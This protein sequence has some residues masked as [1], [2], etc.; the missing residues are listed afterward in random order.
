MGS[1]GALSVIPEEAMLKIIADNIDDGLS[2]VN[3]ALFRAVK[4]AGGDDNYTLLIQWIQ[5]S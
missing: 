2:A 4:A 1:D 5:C 3:Q